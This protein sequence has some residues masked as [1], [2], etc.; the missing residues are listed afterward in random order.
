[1]VPNELTK[2]T[3]TAR[4]PVRMTPL[5]APVQIMMASNTLTTVNTGQE[6]SQIP[7]LQRPPPVVIRVTT[8]SITPTTDGVSEQ[9]MDPTVRILASLRAPG[10]RIRT[11]PAQVLPKKPKQHRKFKP[12]RRIIMYPVT[13]LLLPLSTGRAKTSQS[14]PHGN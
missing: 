7:T 5:P 8:G 10:E 1:M 2:S 4:A 9:I 11:K 14:V 13:Q 12:R 6:T 3:R